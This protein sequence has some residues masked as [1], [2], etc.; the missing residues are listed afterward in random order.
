MLSCCFDQAKARKVEVQTKLA[1]L[2]KD[3]TQL[4]QL[5]DGDV[6]A[7]E[8]ATTKLLEVRSPEGFS[9]GPVVPGSNPALG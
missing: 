7:E 1:E 4:S 5:S 6:A 9:H 3:I 8:E 2:Q